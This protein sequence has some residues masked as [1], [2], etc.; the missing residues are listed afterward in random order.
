MSWC[1]QAIPDAIFGSFSLLVF[2]SLNPR[3]GFA[4]N[5]QDMI[6]PRGSRADYFLGISDNTL[7]IFVSESLWVFHSLNQC[8]I[9]IL[10]NNMTT[11]ADYPKII[12]MF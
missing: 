4:A 6:T 2:H 11:I 5:L 7:N 10:K 3:I 9:L 12:D 8:M 1:P